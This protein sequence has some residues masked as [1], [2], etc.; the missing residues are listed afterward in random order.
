MEELLGLLAGFVIRQTGKGVVWAITFGHWQS[1]SMVNEKGRIYAAAGG[2]SYL[3][4]G[5]RFVTN[6]GLLLI[7]FA[8]YVGVA[9]LAVFVYVSKV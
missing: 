9:L 2:L 4:D 1:D 6:T 3:R 7:G 8:F 5:Q